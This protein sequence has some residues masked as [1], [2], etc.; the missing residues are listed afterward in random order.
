M[1]RDL[2]LQRSLMVLSRGNN[3]TGD[4][5]DGAREEAGRR[6]SRVREL[7]PSGYPFL[8]LAPRAVKAVPNLRAPRRGCGTSLVEAAAKPVESSRAAANPAALASLSLI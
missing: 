8:Q 5:E 6:Q 4:A 2:V 3:N 7:G 1:G